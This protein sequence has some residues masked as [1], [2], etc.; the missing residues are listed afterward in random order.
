MYALLAYSFRGKSA[1]KRK[2][3]END[4]ARSYFLQIQR[5]ITNLNKRVTSNDLLIQ[6]LGFAWIF[7]SKEVPQGNFEHIFNPFSLKK[8]ICRSEKL[9]YRENK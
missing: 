1:E 4:L 7:Y 9:E 3:N 8:S 2:L 5:F 6:N